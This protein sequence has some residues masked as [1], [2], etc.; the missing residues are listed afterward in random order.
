VLAGEPTVTADRKDKFMVA[1]QRVMGTMPIF[2]LT[3]RTSGT[4]SVR[5]NNALQNA[6]ANPR[7]SIGQTVSCSS[8]VKNPLKLHKTDAVMTSNNPNHLEAGGV[9]IFIDPSIEH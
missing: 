9:V 6:I 7:V 1:K 2:Q 3:R 8:C 5:A 4:R